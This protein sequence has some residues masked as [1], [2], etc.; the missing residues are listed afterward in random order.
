[1]RLFYLDILT[2]L[3][4]GLESEVDVTLHSSCVL[5]RIGRATV[6]VENLHGE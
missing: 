1:V 6:V 3:L 5:E 2:G 4:F